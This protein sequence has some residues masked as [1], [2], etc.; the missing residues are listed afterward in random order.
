MALLCAS[1]VW[2]GVAKPTRINPLRSQAA[3][4]EV[5]EQFQ[6]TRA[7][8]RRVAGCMPLASV[9]FLDLNEAQ[10][11]RQSADDETGRTAL[12]SFKTTN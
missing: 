10:V 7:T 8:E 1:E 5:G 12:I 2:G 9:T 3:A 11:G 4:V 6:T